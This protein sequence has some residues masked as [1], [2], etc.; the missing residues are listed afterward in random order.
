MVCYEKT[1]NANSIINTPNTLVTLF[2]QN[3]LEQNLTLGLTLKK[4]KE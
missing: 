4:T 1:L 3:H 2:T